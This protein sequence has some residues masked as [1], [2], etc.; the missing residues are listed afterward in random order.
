MASLRHRVLGNSRPTQEVGGSDLPHLPTGKHRES[1]GLCGVPRE[2]LRKAHGKGRPRLVKPP[3]ERG[4]RKKV[5]GR[6]GGLGA[7]RCL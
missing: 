6:F 5:P 1:R 2:G 7:R 4:R 3:G